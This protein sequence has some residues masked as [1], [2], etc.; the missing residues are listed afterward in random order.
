MTILQ[1]CSIYN[2]YVWVF[3][4]VLRHCTFFNHL[5]SYVIFGRQFLKVGKEG[6]HKILWK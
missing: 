2:I 1:D 3:S 4:R 6:K 5:L